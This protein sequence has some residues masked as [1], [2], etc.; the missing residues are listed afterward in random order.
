MEKSD[1]VYI[2]CPVPVEMLKGL[3]LPFLLNDTPAVPLS[4]DETFVPLWYGNARF[5]EDDI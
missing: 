1:Y 5:P 3:P 4:E 2:M